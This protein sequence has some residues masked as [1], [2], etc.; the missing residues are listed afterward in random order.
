[1]KMKILKGP[2]HIKNPME[3][4]LRVESLYQRGAINLT[5]F[6]EMERQCLEAI[7]R[8]LNAFLPDEETDYQQDDCLRHASTSTRESR[9]IYMDYS[10]CEIN[11]PRDH[12]QNDLSS[13]SYPWLP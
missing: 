9:F 12:A 6:I 5:T 8:D 3:V 11:E 13:S 4:A 7:L 10:D 1:M 2:R